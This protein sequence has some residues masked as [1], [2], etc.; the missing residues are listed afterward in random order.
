M[1]Y[2]LVVCRNFTSPKLI[3]A[4]KRNSPEMCPA[5]RFRALLERIVM[6]TSPASAFL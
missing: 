1:S 6:R 5:E 3:P 2:T 4:V